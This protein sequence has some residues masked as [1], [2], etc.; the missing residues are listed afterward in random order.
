MKKD[1]N[2]KGLEFHENIRK[3]YL[4]L[5]SDE[6]VRIYIIDASK[7]ISKIHNEITKVVEKFL[8]KNK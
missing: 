2:Q 3:S 8:T 5:A 7:S 1:L 6:P 4:K